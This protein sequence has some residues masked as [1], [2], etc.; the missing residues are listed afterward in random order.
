MQNDDDDHIIDGEADDDQAP[1]TWKRGKPEH[2]PTPE[3]RAIVEALHSHGV[4]QDEISTYL[5]ITPKTL[6]KHYRFELDTAHITAN[7]QVSKR[8]F[9]EAVKPDGSIAATIFWLKTRARWSET[10]A[11]QDDDE[12]DASSITVERRDARNAE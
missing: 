3:T 11:P 7:M 2:Q 6:R 9:D 12:I 10:A 8:L 5:G 1:A 4:R